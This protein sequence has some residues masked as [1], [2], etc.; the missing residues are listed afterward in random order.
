[1]VAGSLQEDVEGF[2]L[3]GEQRFELH[4]L[5]GSRVGELQEAGMQEQAVEFVDGRLLRGI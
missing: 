5:A 1:V 3:R 4:R 2:Q